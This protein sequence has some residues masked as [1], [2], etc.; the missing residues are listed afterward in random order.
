MDFA[1]GKSYFGG[2]MS[3][4]IR[5][6]GGKWQVIDKV[7]FEKESDLQNMLHESPELVGEDADAV[8]VTTREAGLPGSGYTDLIGVTGDGSIL[9]VETKLARNPEVRRKVIGQVLEYAAYLWG[10]KFDQFDS[11][12]KRQEGK[13]VLDLL[14][15]KGAGLERKELQKQISA[16]LLAGNFSL[17]IAVDEINPELERIISFLGSRTN[18]IRLEGLEMETYKHGTI[19][20]VVPHRHKQIETG[21]STSTP[22]TSIEQILAETESEES[23]KLLRVIMEGWSNAG[24]YFVFGKKGASCRSE[25]AGQEETMF[26]VYTG[27][28]ESTLKRLQQRGAPAEALLEYRQKLAAIPGFPSAKFLNDSYPNVKW[29][30]LNEASVSSFLSETLRLVQQWRKART[31]KA[32]AAEQGT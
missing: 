8:I 17:L 30:A 4:L 18:A 21:A 14:Q 31:A 13:S 27:W 32:K 19:E 16:S 3:L 6:S 24:N 11:I 7:S 5:N 20:L 12:F 10:M 15:E 2:V 23:R 22:G 25:I 26:C 1:E 28:L 9:I 29:E